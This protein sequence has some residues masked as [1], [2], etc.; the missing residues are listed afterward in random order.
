MESLDVDHEMIGSGSWNYWI[1]IHG[2]T[3]SG[4]WN[5]W[6]RIK[7][8]HNTALLKSGDIIEDDIPRGD[9]DFSLPGYPV[10]QPR[11][12]AFSSNNIQNSKIIVYLPKIGY[13]SN[14]PS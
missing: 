8:I 9:L 11:V 14:T 13:I 6:I 10:N 2:I 4:S 7:M 5:Y 3:G 1:L 12:L